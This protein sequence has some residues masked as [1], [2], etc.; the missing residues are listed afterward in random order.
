MTFLITAEPLL[1]N[2]NSNVCVELSTEISGVREEFLCL[3]IPQCCGRQIC[4]TISFFLN[5]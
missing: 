3:L 1:G 2:N 4:L 5:T